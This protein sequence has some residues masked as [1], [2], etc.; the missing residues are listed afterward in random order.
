LPLLPCRYKLLLAA[1][2]LVA[3]VP[4]SLRAEESPERAKQAEFTKAYGTASNAESRKAA[5]GTLAGCQEKATL[6][7]LYNIATGDRDRDV[8]TEA[9][10]VLAGC[11]DQDGSLTGMVVQAFQAQRD[12]ESKAA[13]ASILGKLP[14]KQFPIQALIAALI[15]LQ[16]PDLPNITVLQSGQQDPTAGIE[17]IRRIFSAILTAINTAGGQAF[18]PSRTVKNEVNAWW[19]AK[20]IE[21]AKADQE[22]LKGI[23]A[24]LDEKKK[25]EAEAKKAEAK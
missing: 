24:A 17:K 22:Y 23:K 4:W 19:G 25:A 21:F 3:F 12:S 11:V 20:Q 7:A 2:L 6:Q 5:L 15:P 13:M 8:R 1:T 14:M 18:Q 9:L 16:Y 10:S